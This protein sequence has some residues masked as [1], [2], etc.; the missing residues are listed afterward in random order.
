MDHRNRADA[1]SDSTSDLFA[2]TIELGVEARVNESTTANIIVKAEDIGKYEDDGSGNNTNNA[3]RSDNDEKPF[4]DEAF[5]TIFN[6]AKCPFYAVLGKRGQPFGQLFT[7]TIND[8]IT[9]DAYEI[10]TT[11]ATVGYAPADFFD[12]DASLT[13][14][15]GEKVMGQGEPSGVVRDAVPVPVMLR[16]MMSRLISSAYL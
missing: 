6:Q 2:S 13:V 12:L 10:A 1:N 8:P 4:I 14:Y 11:G 16:Q 15:K 3:A 7:H 5:I 9:K